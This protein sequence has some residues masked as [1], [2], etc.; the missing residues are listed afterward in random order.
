MKT[1]RA[2]IDSFGT[3]RLLKFSEEQLWGFWLYKKLS[4]E[5]SAHFEPTM[6]HKLGRS[7]LVLSSKS[8]NSLWSM[9]LVGTF[10][11]TK[12]ARLLQWPFFSRP[13]TSHWKVHFLQNFSKPSYLTRKQSWVLS[14]GTTLWYHSLKSSFRYYTTEVFSRYQDFSGYFGC[15]DFLY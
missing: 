3:P 15:F 13:R 9:F 1:E 10:C 2:L 12:N 7:W 5:I 4:E 8:Y 11:E 6:C 14:K